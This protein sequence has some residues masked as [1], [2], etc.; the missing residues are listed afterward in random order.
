VDRLAFSLHHPMVC[1]CQRGGQSIL[2]STA[3]SC[4]AAVGGAIVPGDAKPLGLDILCGIDCVVSC[5]TESYME[6]S[7]FT[8]GML[9]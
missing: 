3:P 9:I 6:K 4:H 5:N 1:S 7:A 2:T 8:E